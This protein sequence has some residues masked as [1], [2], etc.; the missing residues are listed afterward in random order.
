MDV[1]FL[2]EPQQKKQVVRINQVG[3]LRTGSPKQS[4]IICMRCIPNI[5]GLS[6]KACRTLSDVVLVLLCDPSI[7]VRD[8]CAQQRQP[9][10]TTSR[11]LFPILS[12]LRDY[13]GTVFHSKPGVL[14]QLKQ[15]RSRVHRALWPPLLP[16]S[17]PPPPS[18]SP[19]IPFSDLEEACLGVR[20]QSHGRLP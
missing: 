11:T 20:C 19:L 6:E 2:S 13:P 16:L 3:M 8:V 12:K 4:D 7:A 1:V 15:P 17:P 9:E 18:S 14:C 5:V 10:R